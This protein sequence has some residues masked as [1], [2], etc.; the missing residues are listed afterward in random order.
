MKARATATPIALVGVAAIAAAYAY[1]VDRSTVSDADRSA[2]RK[3]VF[4]SFRTDQAT[5]VEL[6]RD[7][8]SLVLERDDDAGP[9]ASS[10]WMMTSPRRERA[11]TAAV[12]LLLRELELATRVRDVTG[13]AG[14]GLDAPRARGRVT[15]GRL[16][17]RFAL[18][19][20]ALRPDGAAYMSID[21]EGAFVVER[22]LKVQLL[23]GADAYRDRV[24]VPFG[25]NDVARLEVR[26]ADGHGFALEHQSGAFRVVGERLRA[27]RTAAD[28]LFNALADAR[29]ESFLGDADADRAASAAMN[30]QVVP[31]DPS[32][33]D[34]ELQLGGVCPGH[35]D[36]V[37]VVQ[38][39]RA[40][41]WQ[42]AACTSNALFEAMGVA[43]ESLVDTAPLLASSDEIE[44]IR[45][46]STEHGGPLVEIARKGTGW[47]ERAPSDRDL[48]PQE[49]ESANNLAGALAGARAIEVHAAAAG[50]HLAMRSR[51]IIV[52]I[53]DGASETLELSAPGPDDVVLARRLD[54]GAIL[55]LPRAV[56]R[57]FEPHP[58]ALRSREIWRPPFDA[59]AVVAIDNGC[60]AVAERLEL[61]NNLWAMRSPSGFAPDALSIADLAGAIAHAKADVWIDESDEGNFGFD[62]A[63][64]CTV[65]L[66]LT[67]PAIDGGARRVSVLFGA[68]GDGGVYA[69]AREDPAVFV[70]PAGLRALVSHPSID[71]NRF[72]IDPTVLKSVTF[73]RG[74]TP[75]VFERTGDRLVPQGGE[76]G[77]AGDADKLEGAL[78]GLHAQTALHLGAPAAEEGMSRPT[79]E[80]IA[81]TRGGDAGAGETRIVVGAGARIDGADAYF[82]RVSG[83]DATFAVPQRVVAAVV[84]AL[85]RGPGERGEAHE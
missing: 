54:D 26:T 65:A 39:L 14:L 58:V 83:I 68:N 80:I 45:L 19:A 46:E 41:P 38:R 52:R 70:A 50:E 85:S 81:R 59:G 42:R 20:D 25:V 8:E 75:F 15:L 84:D 60:T 7:R 6:E 69:R 4:P 51:A 12:D 32:R 27:A 48:D 55:R 82:A 40:E 74:S 37:I 56:A 72:R 67:D 10:A 64:S 16:Q 11:E 36:D 2:R 9:G 63:G 28:R 33:R 21:D 49:S 24:L 22:S 57:R 1:L 35:P 79:L 77:E 3:D 66:T 62:R 73:V 76:A 43:P 5:R 29:A 13:V 61:R 17:Y 44:Q 18:G 71:R 78:E 31:R 47:H 23:R 34:V 30:V 53:R